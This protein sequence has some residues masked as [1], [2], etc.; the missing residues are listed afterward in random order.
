[1]ISFPANGGAVQGYLALPPGGTG[2]GLVVIQEWWGLVG[3]IKDLCDRFAAQGYV[4]LAPDHYHGKQTT[5]PDEAGKMFMA[6]NIAAAGTEMRGA[7]EYL[8]GHPAVAPKKVGIL[9]FCMGGQ[10]ALYAAQEHGDRLSCAVDFYGVHPHVPIN[11]ERVEIPV[12]GHFGLHDNSV[13]VD[14]VKALAAKVAAAG[15]SFEAH[16]YDAGHAF[17]NDTRPTAYSAEA[18]ALAWERTLGFLGKHLRD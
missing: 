3:H 11:P 6:L 14:G 7:A 2:P 12:L 10:L 9:G 5:S 16:F 18:A 15:G 4:A 13:P 8:L 17:F 1:M